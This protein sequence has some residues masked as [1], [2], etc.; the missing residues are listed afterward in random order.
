MFSPLAFPSGT[1]LYD[2][3]TSLPPSSHVALSPFEQF[4]EP[5]LVIGIADAAEYQWADESRA[6]ENDQRLLKTGGADVAE[7]QSTVDELVEQYPKACLH[8]LMFFDC[9]SSQRPSQLPQD[10]IVVPPIS[11][12]RTTT[13]KTIIS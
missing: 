11:Q 2:F 6:T 9:R 10:T 7:L 8:S 12:L 3:S 1:L 13:M 5:F 4:R